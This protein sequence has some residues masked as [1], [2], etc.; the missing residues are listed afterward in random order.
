MRAGDPCTTTEPDEQPRENREEPRKRETLAE[1]ARLKG[2]TW[3]ELRKA[4]K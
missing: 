3:E 4:C 2:T 1:T